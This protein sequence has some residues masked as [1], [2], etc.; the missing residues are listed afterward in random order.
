MRRR[1]VS[2]VACVAV[3][4]GALALGERP[5]GAVQKGRREVVVTDVPTRCTSTGGGTTTVTTG[6]LDIGLNFPDHYVPALSFRVAVTLARGSGAEAPTAKATFAV[7]GPATKTSI[8]TKHPLGSTA[9][10]QMG[11]TATNAGGN[12]TISI[13][14]I[15]SSTLTMPVISTHC[16]VMNVLTGKPLPQLIASIP[17]G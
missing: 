2:A 11:V 16:D 14:S 13:K 4:M 9:W 17:H 15:D 10:Q 1:L 8:S 5:A 6:T 7:G 3:S 12:I